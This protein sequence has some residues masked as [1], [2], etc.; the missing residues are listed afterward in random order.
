MCV[1]GWEGLEGCG[2]QCAGGVQE[3]GSSAGGKSSPQI[4]RHTDKCNMH[5]CVDAWKELIHSR[6]WSSPEK[7][8]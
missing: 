6:R 8:E 1:R 3:V 7:A 4:H 5:V 2:S